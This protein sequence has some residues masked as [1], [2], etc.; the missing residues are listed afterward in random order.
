[1][2]GIEGIKRLLQAVQELDHEC[3][4]VEEVCVVEEAVV[5]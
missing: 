1:M 4:A 5:C 2:F 3:I